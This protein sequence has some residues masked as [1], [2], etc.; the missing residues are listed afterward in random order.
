MKQHHNFLR[1]QCAA[2]LCSF[3]AA[4]SALS[5]S[6]RADEHYDVYN[7]NRLGEAIP[8]QA[9]Y[10]AER[11][12]SGTDLGTAALSNPQDLF[13]DSDGCFYL[14]DTGNQRILKI[15][16]DFSRVLHIYDRF[17]MPDGSSTAL[18]TPKGVFRSPDTGLLYIA[19][20]DNSRALVCTEDG[21]VVQEITKPDSALYDAQLTFLPQKI[22]CDR[23][24]NIYIILSNTTKGAAMFSS[25]G[26]FIGYYGANAVAR[27]AKVLADHFWNAIASEEERRHSTRTAPTAFDNFDLD[28]EKGFIFTS[29]SSEISDT[30]TVKKVNPEGYNLFSYMSDYKW[31]DLFSAWYSG[32]SYKTKIIDLD[33]GA[34][35]SI[36]CLDQ[37]T[38][39]V[40]QYDKEANLLFIMGGTG[41]QT[42]TFSASGNVSA[43]ETAG[44]RCEQIYVLDAG[45]GT[46]TV[47]A[48]TTFGRTVHEATALYNGGYYE[49]ALAP[50]KEVLRRDGNY[51]RAYLGIA[52]A[53]YN[54]GRYKDSMDYAKKAD[55]SRSY[56]RAFERYRAEWLRAHL[57]GILLGIAALTAAGLL[58]RR[59]RRR[60]RAGS[61]KG[62]AA[63]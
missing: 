9:G 40:F 25:D 19:D 45:K 6:V 34:D 36:N 58:F 29:T 44:D 50:W 4:A 57:N 27:T 55:A 35:G 51:R 10:L 5:L 7:Y 30:D 48:E 49:E 18:K 24:G 42:G 47:F 41:D 26:E 20:T 59:Y 32:T 2:I 53:Y 22:L 1:R 56:N 11:T 63:V 8:S 60:R 54:M 52:S 12:V 33:I 38:G 13:R 62:G 43:I 16:R 14:A 28:T 15:D 61:G 23:A 39:R 21:S 37:K 46:V 3:A 17:T 31:G